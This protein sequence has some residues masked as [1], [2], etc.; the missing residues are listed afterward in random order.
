MTGAARSASGKLEGIRVE[1][2]TRA[3]RGLLPARVARPSTAED[4]GAWLLLL[5]AGR[6]AATAIAFALVAW[7]GFKRMDPVLLLY[8]PASTLLLVMFPAVRRSPL[9]WT[10]DSTI[11]LAMVLAS[12]DWRSPFYLLWLASLALPATRLSLKRALWMGVASAI[13]YFAVAVIG[14]PVPG[15]LQLMSTETLAI[16]V[17]LPFMLVV[18]L[19]Y[20]A[21]AL[22]RLSAERSARE[23]LAIEAE[24]KRI[25]W[26]L[27][28][29]AKQRL[30]A[31][32]LLVTSLHGRIPSPLDQTIARAAIELESAASDMDTS[33]AELRSPLE[34]RRLD[35]ALRSRVEEISAD[36]GPRIHVR[37]TAPEL[38]PLVGAHAYRI[39]SE[40]LT[41]ALRHADAT[42]I[43]IDVA[44][45]DGSLHIAVTDDGR[46]MP[47]EARP[48]ATGL[49]AMDNRAATIGAD[50]TAGP[51]TPDGTGTRIE[52]VIP[53][54]SIGGSQ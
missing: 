24:R 13:T 5:V 17:S 22:R 25:A 36:G 18:S 53:L 9:A 16:H 1:V 45:R 49:L 38:P 10:A 39:A 32:H 4:D 7:A 34:G 35:E 40:A 14:G 8:G 21:E 27:H 51:A 37:G 44:Q 48:G 12:G 46:G 43:E 11:T 52:L 31:A 15:R 47:E 19:A 6:L 20:A 54:N 50:L 30:H 33:L 41:N 23:R 26:D 28:D 42:T 2:D 3:L 29:S